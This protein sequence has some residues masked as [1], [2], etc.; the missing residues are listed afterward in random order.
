MP[1]DPPL[2]PGELL[3]YIG[4]HLTMTLHSSVK[5]TVTKFVQYVAKMSIAL[6]QQEVCDRGMWV[7]SPIG[8]KST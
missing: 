7:G 3:T 8:V 2:L 5:S 4:K 6:L 1:G